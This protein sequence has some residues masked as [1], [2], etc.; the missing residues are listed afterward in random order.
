MSSNGFVGFSSTDII[1]REP[2]SQQFEGNQNL[3]FQIV[4]FADGSFGIEKS[5]KDWIGNKTGRL[6]RA[7]LL[8]SQE[9]LAAR[10]GQ[11]LN[12]PIR[13]CLFTNT[14]GTTVIM[15]FVIGQSGRELGEKDVPDDPQGLQL[16]IFD[17]L[18]ANSDRRPKNL[19]FAQSGIVG[20]D[21]ALCNFRP[22]SPKPELLASLYNSGIKSNTIRDLEPVLETTKPYF[23][24]LQMLD[25]YENLMFNLIRLVADLQIV[26]QAT[27]V[28]KSV[29]KDAFTPPKGVQ[30]AAQKALEWL[31]EGKAGDGFTPVG[32]KRASDLA[33]GAVV[34]EDTIR[35]MKAYFDRHQPDKDSPHWDEPSPGKVAW[36][37]W[38]GDAGYSWAK[39]VVESLNKVQKGDV[40]GHEFHGNQWTEAGKSDFFGKTFHHADY[41]TK[42]GTILHATAMP[43][44][45]GG[46]FASVSGEKNGYK[47]SN[48]HMDNHSGQDNFKVIAIDQQGN[49]VGY[50]DYAIAQSETTPHIEMVETAPNARGSGLATAM[51]HVMSA[52]N[53]KSP[54]DQGMLTDD[55]NKWWNSPQMEQ[56]RAE[57]S[58]YTEYKPQVVQKGDTVGHAFHGNQY[59]SAEIASA[60]Q[61]LKDIIEQNHAIAPADLRT[62][63]KIHQSI[64]QMHKTIDD[65]SHHDAS[66]LH[67][68]AANNMNDLADK[69]TALALNPKYEYKPYE[70]GRFRNQQTGEILSKSE[71]ERQLKANADANLSLDFANPRAGRMSIS[72][73][74]GSVRIG[75]PSE[76]QKGDVPGHVFHGNQWETGDAGME[77]IEAW[78]A[79]RTGGTPTPEPTRAP[80]PQSAPKAPSKPVSGDTGLPSGWRTVGKANGRVTLTSDR[81]NSAIFST[82]GSWKSGDPVSHMFL[83]AIDGAAT[84]KTINFA[85]KDI[86]K[87][88]S[89]LAY[90]SRKAPDTI[91]IMPKPRMADLFTRAARDFGINPELT[92][93]HDSLPKSASD[94][95]SVFATY[96]LFAT[97]ENIVKAVTLHEL[98]HSTFFAAKQ[99]N[100]DIYGA[101]SKALGISTDTIRYSERDGYSKLLGRGNGRGWQM[102]DGSIASRQTA[103]DFLVKDSIGSAPLKGLGLQDRLSGGNMT[104]YGTS[105]LQETV[106]EAYCAYRMPELPKTPLVMSLAETLGWTQKSVGGNSEAPTTISDIII[107]DGIDGPVLI[108]GDK[109]YD[110]ETGTWGDAWETN[111]DVVE[112]GDLPGHVFHGNQYEGGMGEIDAWRERRAGTAIPQVP[113]D[114]GGFVG[115]KTT[116]IAKTLTNRERWGGAVNKG[117]DTVRLKD[118]SVGVVKHNSDARAA[119]AEVLSARIGKAMGIPIRDAEF[120]KGGQPT[121]TIHPYIEGRTVAEAFSRNE[122][123][124]AERKAFRD[125]PEMGKIKFLDM[126]TG[127]IDRHWGNVMLRP[128]KT[129]VGIDGGNAFGAMF[130]HQELRGYVIINKVDPAL[131]ASAHDAIQGLFKMKDLTPHQ[132]DI[133]ANEVAPEWQAFWDNGGS[134]YAQTGKMPA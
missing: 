93:L 48:E 49:V 42:D 57:A 112:K 8:A 89:V 45:D 33:R 86:V 7:E 113:A 10:V 85:P 32:R 4:R 2:S 3:G 131:V 97:H 51:F 50:L 47:I 70:G 41:T 118:G 66:V 111:P 18:V 20:I 39:S 80:K 58:T 31:K 105:T 88:D 11:A 22:R 44:V 96:N 79:R 21:H 95:R 6:Y 23:A 126:I 68:L 81:G 52:N 125:S 83:R 94:M 19:M 54:A 26:E 38:G 98:G 46:T 92:A 12:A 132:Q 103:I 84:G 24:Q 61:Q 62:I 75:N 13:D 56:A 121:D 29:K 64:A 72:A 101:V 37:A 114:K 106:A 74:K 110:Y 91:E 55:G 109:A 117:F 15:P 104:R 53:P 60:A 129:I 67:T 25:K 14:D 122:I 30:E 34:S 87:G 73:C 71:M 124:E 78:R 69:L 59:T 115:L 9:Y 5:M 63:A 120:V 102:P 108:M 133:V 16:R 27:S 116:E 1:S 123:S 76:I 134:T 36:Y 99:S 90:V 17:H 107:A 43:H 127:N 40:K 130:G 77:D 100:E 128:D 82:R 119:D 28:V 35:R 65:P